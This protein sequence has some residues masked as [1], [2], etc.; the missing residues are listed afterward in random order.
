MKRYIDVSITLAVLVALFLFSLA[1]GHAQEDIYSKEEIIQKE[2]TYQ[3]HLDSTDPETN[4]QKINFDAANIEPPAQ[5]KDPLM[6]CD[7][8]SVVNIHTVKTWKLRKVRQLNDP[9]LSPDEFAKKYPNLKDNVKEINDGS[10]PDQ[11]FIA[12]R[13]LYERGLLRRLPTGKIGYETEQAVIKFQHLKGF[14]E[15]DAARQIT[16][17]GPRTIKELNALKDRLQDPNYLKEKPLPEVG[18]KDL[19]EPHLSRM[20]KINQLVEKPEADDSKRSDFP[21]SA[22]NVEIQKPQNNGSVVQFQGEAVIQK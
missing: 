10:P 2:S 21:G 19:G 14:A 3:I 8:E 9:L 16:Y 20:Q 22:G 6:I 4:M 1:I 18:E 15:Y 17:I 13:I 7:E 11:K 5:C 12:Q